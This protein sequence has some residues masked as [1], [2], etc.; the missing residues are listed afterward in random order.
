MS[1]ASAE[2]EFIRQLRLRSEANEGVFWTSEGELA[3]FDPEAAK[4]VN[5]A[6]YRDL[7]LPAKL[8]DVVR[9]REG[10]PFDWKTIRLAWLEQLRTL[11]AAESLRQLYDRMDALFEAR[12]ERHLDLMWVAQDVCTQSL[13]PT[14]IEG[15]SEREYQRVLEDQNYKLVRLLRTESG[16]K[17]RWSELKKELKSAWI[18]YQGGAAVRRELRGRAKGERPRQ[19]DLTDPI[20][21]MLPHLGIDRAVDA[22]TTVLTAIAGPPGAAAATLFYELV[23][24]PDWR[25][26]IAEEMASIEPGDLDGVPARVAPVTYRFVKEALRM[27]SPPLLMTRPVRTD[28]EVPR[29]SLKEGQR[30]LLSTYFI[31]HDARHWQ[32]PDTFDPDRWLRKPEGAEGTSVDEVGTTGSSSN[33]SS[34]S[35]SG[36]NGSG[37]GGGGCPFSSPFV[38]FGWAPKTCVGAGLGTVQLMLLCHLVTTRYRLDPDDADGITIDLAAVPLPIGFEGRVRRRSAGA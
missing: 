23:R 25:A 19:L 31:H 5:A 14:V 34:S 38:P 1:E 22:V 18:Q 15:L 26:R 29:V 36:T 27:W 4:R 32:D 16:P 7:T 8:A 3:V 35:G 17:T 2:R 6:N 10:E 24:R 20:V 21:E 37:S 9:G 11:S 13:V 33:G 28:I 12:L 30:Y